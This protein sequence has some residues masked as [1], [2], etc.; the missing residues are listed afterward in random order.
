MHLLNDLIHLTFQR[1]N[2]TTTEYELCYTQADVSDLNFSEPVVA[3]T[4]SASFEDA[5]VQA[6]VFFEQQV[7]GIACQTGDSL[8][9][10]ISGDNGA[11]WLEPVLVQTSSAKTEDCD[12]VFLQ[13][14]GSL[15]EDLIIIWAQE[16]NPGYRNIITRMGHFIED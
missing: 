15:S 1:R 5:H 4:S 12:M 8:Y 16:D 13:H 3:D 11:T 7:V 6:G 2:K 14:T 10:I 9:F